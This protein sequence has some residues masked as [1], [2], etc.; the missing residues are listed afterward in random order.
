MQG[1][2]K[3]CI[4]LQNL[5]S[6]AESKSSQTHLNVFELV[7]QKS[8]YCFSANSPAECAEWIY[9]IK[10]LT[11][12]KDIKNVPTALQGNEYDH[13]KFTVCQSRT[14]ALFFA[15]YSS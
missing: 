3:H 4:P 12:P 2:N 5:T 1:N 8:S 10:D 9:M 13:G 15:R 11:L 7:I 6:I 14:R